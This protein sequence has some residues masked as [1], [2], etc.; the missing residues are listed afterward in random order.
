MKQEIQKSTE[1]P[2]LLTVNEA[3]ALLNIGRN[4]LRSLL[5]PGPR[6]S[7]P[8]LHSV[9]IGNAYRIPRKALDIFIE[10]LMQ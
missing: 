7:P 2:L 3:A 1:I 10:G 4:K 6:N 9:K 5:R 8:P